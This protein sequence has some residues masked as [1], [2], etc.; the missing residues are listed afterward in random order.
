M[1]A[2]DTNVLVW[3]IRKVSCPTRPDLIDRCVQLIRDHKARHIE[4]MIPSIVLAEFLTGQDPVSQ[5]SV[6]E[7]IGKAFFIAPFDA[8]AAVI[9]AELFDKQ[10][11]DAAKQESEV[12][13]QCLKADYKILATAI[14]HGASAIYAND[15]HF[16][17]FAD[18]KIVVRDIPLMP[19]AQ[20]EL[21]KEGS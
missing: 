5:R 10:E 7:I 3:G 4:I 17:K 15:Q 8:K 21:F 14:A 6:K 2:L 16:I 1:I 18:G 19:R 20:K 13:R 12:G 9:A 11:F